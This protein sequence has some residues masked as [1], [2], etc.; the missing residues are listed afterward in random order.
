VERDC[1]KGFGWEERELWNFRNLAL[2]TSV[3][4]EVLLI[5]I[6]IRIMLIVDDEA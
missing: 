2:I 6:E 3:N 4:F 5:I 1:A